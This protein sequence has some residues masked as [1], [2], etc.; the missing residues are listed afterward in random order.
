MTLS[1]SRLKRLRAQSME[2]NRWAKEYIKMHTGKTCIPEN[3]L[4]IRDCDYKLEKQLQFDLSSD[5]ISREEFDAVN[6][7]VAS[8]GKE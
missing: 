6:A 4:K 7:I 8:E 5:F 2:L 1:K 3:Q